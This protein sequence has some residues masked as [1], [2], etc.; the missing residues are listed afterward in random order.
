MKQAG[1]AADAAP[2]RRTDCAVAV[3][4]YPGVRVAPDAALPRRAWLEG[5]MALWITYDNL[6]A[7]VGSEAS[8]LLVGALGGLDLWVPEKPGETHMLTRVMGADAA[9][10]LCAAYGGS[11]IMVPN[12]RKRPSRAR[13][14]LDLLQKGESAPRIAVKLGITVRYVRHLAA[15]A[16]HKQD[17]CVL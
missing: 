9:K 11:E 3:A 13:E 5:T 16:K 10:K 6:V 1:S 15:R 7:I 14:V 12:G 2:A 8:L 17:Q 4:Q